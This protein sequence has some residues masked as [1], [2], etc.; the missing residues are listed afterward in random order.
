MSLQCHTKR[1]DSVEEND[2]D[3]SENSSNEDA[4][5]F[6]AFLYRLISGTSNI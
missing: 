1:A 6:A 3:D 5:G 2:S 4:S